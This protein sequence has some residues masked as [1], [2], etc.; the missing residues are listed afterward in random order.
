MAQAGWRRSSRSKSQFW[1]RAS[2]QPDP[3]DGGKSRRCLR[4][5]HFRKELRKLDR[6]STFVRDPRV[7]V[8]EDIQQGALLLRSGQLRDRRRHAEY[9]KSYEDSG[10]KHLL[11]NPPG[12]TP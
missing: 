11:Q 9:K 1:W 7:D 3:S 12:G 10:D 5:S 8:S 4:Y 2:I 6:F